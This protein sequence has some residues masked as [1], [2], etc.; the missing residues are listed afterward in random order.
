MQVEK[1]PI[2]TRQVAE[3]LCDNKIR[4]KLLAYARSRFGI[5]AEDAEDL[6]QDTAVELF[7]QRGYVRRPEG[8]VFA[9]FRASCA[10]FIGAS[11]AKRGIFQEVE[12]SFDAF[13]APVSPE[14][15][16]R[17]IFLTE[18]LSRVSTTCLRLLAAYYAE[19]HDLTETASRLSLA[20]AS[21][22]KTLSRC[23]QRLRR[24]MT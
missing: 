9:V 6:L 12:T 23:L 8:F 13:P 7:R 18:A 24:W 5:G 21:V 14:R 1:P 19:G 10:R 2:T 16:D 11:L 4:G 15:L 3:V 20:R 22:G 17:Q